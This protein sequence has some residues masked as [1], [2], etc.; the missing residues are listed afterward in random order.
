MNPQ[1]QKHITP[2]IE[3]VSIEEVKEITDSLDLKIEKEFEAG[4]YHWGLFTK[5]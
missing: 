3:R 5:E 4:I 1:C 2:E